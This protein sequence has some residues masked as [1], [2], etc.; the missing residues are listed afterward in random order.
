MEQKIDDNLIASFIDDKLSSLERLVYSDSMKDSIIEEIIEVSKDVKSLESRLGG[1]E[2]I[3]IPECERYL[4]K[5]YNQEI[6]SNIDNKSKN[7]L[8]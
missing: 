5:I 2:P 6:P 3:R 1:L 7:K 8:F 4:E